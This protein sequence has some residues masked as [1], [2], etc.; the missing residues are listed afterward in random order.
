VNRLMQVST[1]VRRVFFIV[2]PLV[3]DRKSDQVF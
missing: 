2:C 3:G 1:K